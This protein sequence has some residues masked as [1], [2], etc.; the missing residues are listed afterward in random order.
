MVTMQAQGQAGKQ[1]TSWGPD[2]HGPWPGT[3]VA[4]L[5][6]GTPVVSLGQ[7]MKGTLKWGSWAHGRG[8]WMK[9]PGVAGHC[10]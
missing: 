10:H 2:Q 6:T 5:E 9:A 4:E 8:V 7:G 1:L 3:A